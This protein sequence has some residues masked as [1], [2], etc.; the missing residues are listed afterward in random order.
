[1]P[2]TTPGIQ[3]IKEELE[4]GHWATRRLVSPTRW[5]EVFALSDK[6]FR[7]KMVSVILRLLNP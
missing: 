3:K 4:W 1:M 5:E 7:R 2:V 6:D